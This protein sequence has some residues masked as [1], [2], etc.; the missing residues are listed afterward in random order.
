[1][2][3]EEYRLPTIKVITLGPY[4]I[5]KTCLL[6]QIFKPY[7]FDEIEKPFIVLC[8]NVKIKLR[9]WDTMSQERYNP[10][11]KWYLRNSDVV[12]ICYDPDD[13]STISEDYQQVV[14]YL[15]SASI[16]LVATKDDL[17]SEEKDQLF[18]Q[19][20]NELK[21]KYHASAIIKVSSYYG[22]NIPQL[23]YTITKIAAEKIRNSSY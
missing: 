18:D 7:T 16:I 11:S 2:E 17:Y 22:K 5:G 6:R 12:L 13:T 15:P 10:M 9:L 21:E 8:D 4:G 1:M 23:I 19:Q 20:S 3:E 14:D